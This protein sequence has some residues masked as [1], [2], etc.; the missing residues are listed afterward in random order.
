MENAG[1]GIRDAGSVENAGS[2]EKASKEYRLI[3][4]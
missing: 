1:S 2:V 3:H 4:N